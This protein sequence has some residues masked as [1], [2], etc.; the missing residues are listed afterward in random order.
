VLV[1]FGDSDQETAAVIVEVQREGTCWAGGTRWQGR[2]AM[3]VSI[4]GCDTS[5]PDVDRSAAAIRR[6][7]EKVAAERRGIARGP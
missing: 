5:E 6:V 7:H 3:R 2:T 4:S 1:R